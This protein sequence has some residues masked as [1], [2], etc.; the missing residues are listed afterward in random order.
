MSP[1]LMGLEIGHNNDYNMPV[2]K[3]YSVAK[4]K[5]GLS[6]ILRDVAGGEEVVVTDHNRPVAK[7]SSLR[8]VAP[9]PA[10]DVQGILNFELLA[11]KRGAEGAASL[12][13]RLRNDEDP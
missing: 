8:G 2:Y 6:S 7:L 5:A 13:R 11:L 12:I 4:L 3:V 10:Y 9:L 1:V